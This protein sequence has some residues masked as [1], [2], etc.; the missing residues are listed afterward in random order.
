MN[1]EPK[2]FHGDT[3]KKITT[4]MMLSSPIR[5][6]GIEFS[7]RRSLTLQR[8]L[9]PTPQGRKTTPNGAVVADTDMNSRVKLSLVASARPY[10]HRCKKSVYLLPHSVKG[11]SRHQP[12]DPSCRHRGSLSTSAPHVSPLS[13]SPVWRSPCRT[14]SSPQ[15]AQPPR[16]RSP[17]PRTLAA[18]AS[19]LRPARLWWP[20]PPPPCRHHCAPGEVALRRSRCPRRRRCARRQRV[21][22]PCAGGGGRGQAMA[23]QM[24]PHPD[25]GKEEPDAAT[26]CCWAWI[27]EGGQG[28][29][30]HGCSGV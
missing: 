13:G 8:A 3:F 26:T 21:R 19:S 11:I 22:G 7:P 25:L 1:V 10:H 5:R 12:P 14:Q 2:D 29:G 27:S 24:G 20:P 6:G 23:A 18:A 30:G 9:Q 17:V 4:S 16:R 28:K 15:I